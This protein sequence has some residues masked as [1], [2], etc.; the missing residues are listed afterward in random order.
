MASR[1][2]EHSYITLAHLQ[3]SLITNDIVN[4]PEVN[5]AAWSRDFPKRQP[6][7][8]YFSVSQ[9]MTDPSNV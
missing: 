2:S 6:S 1:E 4:Q 3:H 9:K 8:G 5:P 7:K